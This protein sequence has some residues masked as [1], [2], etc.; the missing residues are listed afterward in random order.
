MLDDLKCIFEEQL[1]LKGG[2]LAEFNGEPDHVRLLI[3]LPPS[4]SLSVAVNNF[5]SVSSRLLRKRH[6]AT[7][8]RFFRRPVLWSRSY[9]ISSVGGANLD[10]VRRYIEGQER[11][12]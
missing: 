3:E 5:K 2:A 11:P 12:L 7:L 6:S 8:S 9:F 1:Q 4:H 10:T